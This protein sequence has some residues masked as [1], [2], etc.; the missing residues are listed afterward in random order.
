MTFEYSA[1][2]LGLDK[3][4][5]PKFLDI[6]RLRP[7]DNN[8]PWGI[9]FIAFDET[10]L[11]VVALR[12]L[13]HKLAKSKRSSS[14]TGERASW[15]ENDLLLISQTGT[16]DGRS[17]SFA[18]FS[19]NPEKK[20]LPILK[21][22]GWD[23][24]DTGLKIE[25]VIKTL[26]EKLVWPDNPSDSEA[27]K[28]QWKEAFTL[29]NR[30]VIQSS[31]EMSERL[32]NLA[33]TIRTRLLALLACE[34]KEGPI[35][36][37]MTLFKENLI[38]DLDNDSFSD[39][40][41]QTIAYGLLSARIVNPK[42]NTADSSYTQIPITN[43]FL[44]ELMETFLNIGGRRNNNSISLDFDELGISDVV[45]LLD[46]TNMEAVIQDFG[47]RN[48]KEDPVMH[49][50]EG[51]LDEYDKKIRRDRGVWYTPNS[52]VSFIVRS[53]DEQLRSEFGME[54]GLADTTTWGEFAKKNNGQEIPKDVS[55][56]QPFVQIL[57]PA[58]GTGTFLVE[59]I[60]LIYNTMN[61]KWKSE[62]NNE[63]QIIELWNKYVPDH[64]L[65]RLYGYELMMAP[66]AIAHI[67][68]G[69]K[70][71]E[72]GYKFISHERVNVFLTNSLE[73]SQ[74][75][76][77]TL[78]FAIP[79]LA[80]EAESVNAVKQNHKFTVVIGN[81]PYSGVSS[82]NGVWIKDLLRSSNQKY[83]T[84]FYEYR[85]KPVKESNT[86]WLNDDYVKFMRLSQSTIA[87]SQTGIHG[88]ITNNSFLDNP[89]FR[90]M[91]ES[92]SKTFSK[93]YLIN[94]HGN[95]KKGDKAPDGSKDENVFDIQQGVAIS[96]MHRN[97]N[98][99][100]NTTNYIDI[101]GERNYKYT[102]LNNNQLHKVK[103]K[104]LNPDN[105]L[106]LWT[107][108]DNTHRDEYEEFLSVTEI[109]SLSGAKSQGDSWA[110]GLATTKDNLFISFN[111]D[112]LI[113]KIGIL[114]SQDFSEK[115]IEDK[116][117]IKNTPYFNITNVR[118]KINE[119]D[120]KQRICKVLYRPFDERYIYWHP[121]LYDVG[122][123]ASS[124]NVMRHMFE[125]NIALITSRM[126]KGE[127]FAHC[128]ISELPVEVISLSSK[129][130]NNAFIFPSIYYPKSANNG[131]SADL[132]NN[133]SNLKP[134]LSME[135]LN[136]LKKCVL[137]T[138]E[139]ELVLE[140]NVGYSTLKYIY[141]ILNS[142]SY[143]ARYAPF[144][145]VE[146]P[147]IPIPKDSKL[148]RVL[149][150][151]GENL[152][153]VHS[154]KNIKDD[155]TIKIIGDRPFKVEKVSYSDETVWIDKNQTRGI[156]NIPETVW[157][158]NI[159]GY[160]VCEKWL[161]DRGPKKGNSGLVLSDDDIKHYKKIIICI[162]ETLC[163]NIKIDKAIEAHGGW[164]DA[165]K[166]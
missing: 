124:K 69:L 129:S 89:T 136:K 41:A 79:S 96:I 74:D 9:F 145:K 54:Y 72:T 126:A 39:M 100:E 156:K 70:L 82:N 115:E 108:F 48:Q 7:L 95:V 35:H 76:S 25:H 67:K 64:L 165:F 44:R 101:Y 58:T 12:R 57:D 92:L 128:F 28:E 91:R 1:D 143:R 15:H 22:L 73:P 43:P 104:V 20:D 52:V 97:T 38:S 127:S 81:P 26:R 66:Y 3:A 53:V 14:N 8:Q 105:N 109:Y 148:F 42:A 120:W 68:I 47:D 140:T 110:K 19:S 119:G 63:A 4:I 21:V 62:G 114:A 45:D 102:T 166:D 150:S 135:F 31:K 80:R 149:V 99:K 55:A 146:F 155:E 29:K 133:E 77:D 117:G 94:L 157:K 5:S 36:K 106:F 87:N 18:H 50:F 11:P 30:E 123:G 34:S 90:G 161:K 111:Y 84:S 163:I 65:T 51:F 164:P 112:D 46:R 132:F 134:N 118:E 116:L 144:L 142:N 107:D 130:S 125:S 83:L 122:R 121:E 131:G 86:R 59:V 56:S 24:D 49:F 137:N 75:F 147:R 61:S 103:W 37:L 141:A 139:E 113:N 98:Q 17:I 159:G 78:S 88:M 153:S 85:D 60:E 23:S 40:Y 10:K 2:E 13:L 158:F 16:N 71:L 33:L 152:I 154:M 151:L 6:R 162:Q 32:G 27:W 138:N 93:C 160:Q